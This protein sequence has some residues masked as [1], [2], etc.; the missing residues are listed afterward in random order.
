WP[1]RPSLNQNV[2][3]PQSVFRESVMSVES[4]VTFVAK[5]R[6]MPVEFAALRASLR[7]P[8]ELVQ[9]ASAMGHPISST[10]AE[11]LIKQS[12]SAEGAEPLTDEGLDCVSAAGWRRNF[13]S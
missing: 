13:F 9:F 4:F 5:I 2:L 6:D 10:E 3:R 12:R 1:E 11:L 7:S 8:R